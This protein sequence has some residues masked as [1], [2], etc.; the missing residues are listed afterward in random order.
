[1]RLLVDV[2]NTALKVASEI[3][4]HITLIEEADIN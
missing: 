2:G 4:G 1:M 3:N